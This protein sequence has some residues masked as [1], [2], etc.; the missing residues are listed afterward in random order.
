MKEK[1][2]AQKEKVDM[3][4]QQERVLVPRVSV[5]S[6]LVGKPKHEHPGKHEQRI[7]GKNA[8]NR[9]S[10][11][12]RNSFSLKKSESAP[13][14]IQADAP[15]DGAADAAADGAADDD[16]DPPTIGPPPIGPPPIGP[17][18]DGPPPDGPPPDGPPDEDQ[19]RRVHAIASLERGLLSRGAPIAPTL[20]SH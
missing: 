6:Q 4:Q 11:L 5:F 1:R 10:R 19:R 2:E 9:R 7:R 15:A 20:I 3:N 16:E 17:P 13:T 14:M 12:S 8:A 18:P